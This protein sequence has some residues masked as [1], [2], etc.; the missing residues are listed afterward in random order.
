MYTKKE[1]LCILKSN[2]EKVS[3]FFDPNEGFKL[4]VKPNV[5]LKKSKYIESYKISTAEEKYL[6]IL[7][8]NPKIVMLEYSQMDYF[9]LLSSIP[10]NKV[11][12]LG[13]MKYSPEKGFFDNTST[14]NVSEEY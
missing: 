5:K 11:K 1:I 12:L 2:K 8:V 13:G 10:R 4:K 14:L 7:T 6:E 3:A 9:V